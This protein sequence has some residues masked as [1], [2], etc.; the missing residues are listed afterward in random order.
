MG[1]SFYAGGS[2][3]T[4]SLDE[5]IS[6]L[7]HNKVSQSQIRV[8]VADH[9]VLSNLSNKGL[10][11]DLYLNQSQVDILV[12]SKSSA[13]SWLTTNV[14]SF[15]PRVNIKSI[16]VI[17]SNDPT[18]PNELPTLLSTLKSLH[19]VL[20]SFHDGREVKVSVA[21]SLSFLK[22]S[23]GAHERELQRI[24][25]YIKEIRSSV[26]VETSVDREALSKGSDRYVQPIIDRANL[27]ASVLACKD[28]PLVL[29]IKSPAVL[30]AN[31]VAEF[32]HKVSKALKNKKQ[33]T[34]TLVEIYAEASA[35]VE[36]DFAEE[37]QREK[38]MVFP[39]FHRDLL[40]RLDLKTAT[41]LHDEINPPTT[42]FPTTP[43]APDSPTPTIVTVPSTVTI[44]PTNPSTPVAVPS[45]T[46][47]TMPPADPGNTPAPV[48]NPVTTPVTVPGGQPTNPVTTYPA[49]P[50][51]VPVTTPVTNPVSPPATNNAPAVP[52]A[53][54]CVAKS[55]APQT[56]LQSAL[57]FA[58]G[59]GGADCSQIQQGGSCYNPNSL[60]NHASFAFNSYYQKNPAPTS[61]DF[62]GTATIVNANPS[63]K[64]FVG[65]FYFPRYGKV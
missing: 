62:G 32:T 6:F 16:V 21:F 63:K 57:D 54:W 20:A 29:S 58:C 49:P 7:E 59:M 3:G 43:V 1:F 51:T 42:T 44:T 31:E 2:T 47:V 22:S 26:T 34:G 40:G 8:F 50:A 65:L 41:L 64:Q 27:A 14:I 61:C 19:S 4:S 46:P 39:S 53:S 55:G 18:R 5:T 52:G 12:K 30:G 9:K 48:T 28:V 13:T 23:S 10:S 37:L 33:N 36:D 17:S 24:F 60:Q 11:V 35:L 15:L 56:A 45:T 38:E 25:T